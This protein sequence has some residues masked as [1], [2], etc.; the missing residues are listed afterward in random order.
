MTSAVVRVKRR[1]TDEPFDKFVLNCK[2]LKT[3]HNL[4]SDPTDAI[5][6]ATTTADAVESTNDTKTILKLAATVSAED[7]LRAHLTKLRK[8]EAEE[9][10]RKVRKPD[11]VINKLR[12]QFK[13]DAQNQ[14]FKVVN[15]FRSI[16]DTIGLNETAEGSSTTQ[17]VTIV[18]VIKEDQTQTSSP[19][20]PN[21]SGASTTTVDQSDSKFVYDLY[22][23]QSGEQP[24]EID[25]SNYTIRPFDDLVYQANDDTLNDSDLDSEDSNDEAH[26]RNEY[27]DTDDGH[28]I[29]EEDMRRAVEDLNFDSDADNLS[30]DDDDERNYVD[31]PVVHFMDES[32][33]E[34][35][36]Y[37]YF[38]KH[39]QLRSNAA[40][41]RTNRHNPRTHLASDEE[42]DID[43]EPSSNSSIASSVSPL[44]SCDANS[45]DN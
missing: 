2:R 16:D 9:I 14:R 1:I 15:C 3:S 19:P 27:P 24:T 32:E 39:G 22:L 17:N 5:A 10:V 25:I 12:E 20:E 44:A 11:R 42:S 26:W 28:S 43:G 41:Y 35:N 23:V 4:L 8:T 37:D 34:E 45:D 31:D 7:D 6:V 18:D 29:G 36:E 30:S 13:D 33:D 40:Y 38:K 21:Q